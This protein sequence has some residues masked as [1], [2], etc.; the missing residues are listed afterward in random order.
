MVVSKYL[1][2]TVK[3]QRWNEKIMFEIDFETFFKKYSIHKLS[4]DYVV[5]IFKV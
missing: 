3:F 4:I 5:Y 1:K 2:N